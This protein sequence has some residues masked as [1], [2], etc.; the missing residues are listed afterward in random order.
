MSAMAQ[1]QLIMLKLVGGSDLG[2]GWVLWLQPKVFRSQGTHER[3]VSGA[4]LLIV[5]V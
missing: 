4:Q 1:K 2:A 3:P 5:E